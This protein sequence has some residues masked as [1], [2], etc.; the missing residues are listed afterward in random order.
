VKFLQNLAV[1][2]ELKSQNSDEIQDQKLVDEHSCRFLVALAI[3]SKASIFN[4]D[5]SDHFIIG[6]SIKTVFLRYSTGKLFLSQSLLFF[7]QFRPVRQNRRHRSTDSGE[8]PK[9]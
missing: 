8:E 4:M 3:F 5:F 7:L 1:L 6:N 9:K 2:Q